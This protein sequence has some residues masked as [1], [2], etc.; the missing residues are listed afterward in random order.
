MAVGAVSY[1]GIGKEAAFGT[2]VV[3]IAFPPISS[4]SFTDGPEAISEAQLRGLLAMDPKYKGMQMVS[5]GF[6][7]IAYPSILGH[8]LRAAFGSPVT[9]GAGPYNHTF[10]PPNAAA[11]VGKADMP[12]YSITVKRDTTQTKRYMGCVLTKL[13]FKF[14][15]GDKLTYDT[16]WIGRDTDIPTAPTLVLPTDTPF[17]LTAALTRGGS[18]DITIQDFS[19]DI[20][21]TLEAVKTINNSNLIDAIRW[22]GKRSI[23]FSGTADFSTTALYDQFILFTAQAYSIIFT[24]GASTFTLELPAGLITAA[25]AAASGDGRMTLSFSGEGQYDVVTAR[26]LRAILV[27]AIASY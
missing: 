18:A 6:N 17:T 21:N 23:T 1:L 16:S 2:A 26:D 8:L 5:G 24:Q 19:L 4:E 10:V 3:P 13:G 15:Q 7:G 20:T 27:N 11:G 14:T 9:T 22:S 25:G 12:P